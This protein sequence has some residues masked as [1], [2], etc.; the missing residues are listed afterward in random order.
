MKSPKK[1]AAS[2]TDDD[3]EDENKQE[4]KQ[5]DIRYVNV[6]S[7]YVRSEHDLNS[8][9]TS[10]TGFGS[11]FKVED[12]YHDEENDIEWLKVT[13][14][15]S[16]EK[17]GWISSKLVSTVA[18]ESS[19]D[20]L[21]STLNDM[22][23]IDMNDKSE[24]LGRYEDEADLGD[25]D[26]MVKDGKITNITL[27][28]DPAGMDEITGQLGEPKLKLKNELFYPGEKYYYLIG[29]DDNSNA[30]RITIGFLKQE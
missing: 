28:T 10:V 4:E 24:T 12:S 19:D 20:T 14:T 18:A 3:A 16:D 29:L 26:Y 6:S 9:A 8:E 15:D 23:G 13:S 11:P 25:R 1:E 5:D 2:Q 27:R 7:A 22:L 17:S 30:E 21:I